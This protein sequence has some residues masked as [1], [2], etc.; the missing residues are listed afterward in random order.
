MD[1]ILAALILQCVAHL[2]VVPLL[3][4]AQHDGEPAINGTPEAA[5]G[6]GRKPPAAGGLPEE[7]GTIDDPKLGSPADPTA[8]A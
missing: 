6:A 2:T 8:G 3:L 4:A 7:K 5:D 1:L